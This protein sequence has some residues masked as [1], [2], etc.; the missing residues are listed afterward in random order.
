MQTSKQHHSGLVLPT[1][2]EWRIP[3]EF[4]RELYFILKRL[5]DITGA[6]VALLIAAVPMLIVALAVKLDSPGPII[7]RQQRVGARRRRVGDR[8]VWDVYTFTFYKFRSMTHNADQN[9]HRE[10]IKALMHNDQAKLAALNGEG[11][12]N[13]THKLVNDRRVTRVGRFIRRTSLD[14]LPQLFNVLKGDISLVGP[15]P[16]IPYEVEEYDNWQH[17]RLA[18]KPGVTG[19]WQV[20]ARSSADFD[21]MVKLDIWYIQHQ[22]L[23]LD[24]QILAKT[25]KAILGGKGAH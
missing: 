9:V 1:R 11:E 20:T 19:W 25:P 17:L 23:W 16:P 6:L 3:Q 13:G 21:E 10:Y 4:K 18:T 2:L 8:E 5:M 15:R 14:E 22:S 7:F 12:K 24:L